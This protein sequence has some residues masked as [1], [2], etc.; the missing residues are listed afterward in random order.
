MGFVSG[1]RPLQMGDNVTGTGAI[2]N[3]PNSKTSITKNPSIID[4]ITKAGKPNEVVDTPTALA[5]GT[6][7][8]TG[9]YLLIGVVL[10]AAV[11]F[12]RRK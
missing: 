2:Y 4:M 10:I 8:K 9:S 3:A 5:A 11:L 7:N 1:F 6:N 12:L